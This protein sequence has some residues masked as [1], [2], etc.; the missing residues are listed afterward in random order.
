M[1]VSR[2][3]RLFAL[4]CASCVGLGAVLIGC[5]PV[6]PEPKFTVS[7]ESLTFEA[8]VGD[9]SVPEQNLR[10]DDP[11][12]LSG[13]IR[14]TA[15]KAWVVTVTPPLGRPTYVG[16]PWHFLVGVTLDG[17]AEGT[18]TATITVRSDRDGAEVLVPVTLTISIQ[19][20]GYVA[21]CTQ[22]MFSPRE[23]GV[24]A[25]DGTSE[26]EMEAVIAST[27]S[28]VVSHAPGSAWYGIKTP[29][30]YGLQE[31]MDDLLAEPCVS[32]CSPSWINICGLAP[33]LLMAEDGSGTLWPLAGGVDPG[34][35][36]V[37]LEYIVRVRGREVDID[38]IPYLDVTSL[39]IIRDRV[40][41]KRGTIALVDR[42]SEEVVVIL[43]EESGAA[44]ELLGPVAEEI[45]AL[46]DVDGK[47]ATIHGCE[48]PLSLTSRAGGL[49]LRVTSYEIE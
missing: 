38:G 41:E 23:L 7:P 48:R 43:V 34:L 26:A 37:V 18:H 39:D 35:E 27:G 40:L 42:G 33:Y 28:T 2:H 36:D 11:E 46:S 25:L 22:T 1:F 21:R 15:D 4:S 10:V 5:F 29:L 17:L 16:A 6:P 32:S 30:G 24:E 47:T 45:A 14:V 13:T 31:V 3:R 12:G 44:W 8:A 49:E 19:A 20:E 9:E